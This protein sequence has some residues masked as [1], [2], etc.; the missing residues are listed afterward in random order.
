[1]CEVL[2]NECYKIKIRG[3]KHVKTDCR[4]VWNRKRVNYKICHDFSFPSGPSS[5]AFPARLPHSLV[6]C[7]RLVSWCQTECSLFCSNSQGCLSVYN[8]LCVRFQNAQL[9]KLSCKH[10]FHDSFSRRLLT[11]YERCATK[12]EGKKHKCKPST[13]EYPP[14]AKDDSHYYCCLG[15]YDPASQLN[16]THCVLHIF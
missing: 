5:P 3:K 13:V 10:V 9:I 11:S 2:L 15:K 16:I 4:V 7:L 1:M 12:D 8:C 6:V 14:H